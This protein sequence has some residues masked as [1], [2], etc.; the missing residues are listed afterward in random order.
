MRYHRRG[1]KTQLGMIAT[2]TVLVILV[3][4]GLALL[5]ARAMAVAGWMAATAG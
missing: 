4:A 2:L 3:I 1:H 5:G